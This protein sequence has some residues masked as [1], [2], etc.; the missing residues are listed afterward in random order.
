MIRALYLH[1]AKDSEDV[2][3]YL[4]DLIQ[5]VLIF[6]ALAYS[7]SSRTNSFKILLGL[8][9]AAEK[10]IYIILCSWVIS[11]RCSDLAFLRKNPLTRAPVFDCSLTNQWRE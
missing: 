11:L 6:P 1:E 8:C 5:S 4:T 3:R 7:N 10:E 9:H 2:L